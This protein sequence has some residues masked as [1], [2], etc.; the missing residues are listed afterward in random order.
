MDQNLI[1]TS[2]T[3]VNQ[4]KSRHHTIVLQELAGAGLL[5]GRKVRLSLIAKRIVAALAVALLVF[6]GF[7]SGFISCLHMRS[8][9]SS[10]VR[11]AY[12]QH[13]GDASPSV[14]L[15]VL[16]ALRAFQD[17][18][19]KR[20]PN[21]LDS[22][23]SRLIAKSDDVLI[24]GTDAGEWVHGYSA[25]AAFIRAD[26]QGWGDLRLEVDDSFICSSGDVAWVDSIGMVHFKGSDRPLRFSAILTRNGSDWLFR[27]MHFQWDEHDPSST[28]LLHPNT[29]LKLVG[30]AFKRITNRAR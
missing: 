26:W 14:R 19:A 12:L 11:N 15:G 25:T 17:G 9:P 4:Q 1:A 7:A 8:A 22:F 13:A 24:V 20:D 27:E 6:G 28:D 10:E 23:A 21:N 2:E 5:R 18:Y 16:T 3:S 29:Y 30:L